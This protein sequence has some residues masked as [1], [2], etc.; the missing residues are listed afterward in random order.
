MLIV[1]CNN[2]NNNN[3]SRGYVIKYGWDH[4]NI[5]SLSNPKMIKDIENSGFDGIMF[6]T[7]GE[8]THDVFS[9]RHVDQSRIDK[10]F[11]ALTPNTFSKPMRNYIMV[12]IDVIE[13]GWKGKGTE[14]MVENMKRFAKAAKESGMEGIAFDNESYR[15]E[16]FTPTNACPDLSE[17]DCKQATIDAGYEMMSAILDVWPNVKFLSFFGIWIKD[18]DAVN[19]I[20]ANS[21]THAFSGK[22]PTLKSDFLI[23]VYAAID[24]R[25]NKATFIDGGEIYGME[26]REE[27]KKMRNYLQ[28]DF[29][30]SSKFFDYKKGKYRQSYI[31]N[32]KISFGIWDFRI[33]T[34]GIDPYKPKRLIEIV[35]NSA[36]ETEYVWLYT[37]K[38]DWWPADGLHDR[39][40]PGVRD[41][42]MGFTSDSLKKGLREALTY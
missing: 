9:S 6:G 27:F 18:K 40:K 1:S 10:A 5:S 3:K 36:K 25:G 31:D 16:P 35:M 11:S 24:E 19:Y 42:A 12:Y 33:P 7:G 39:C 21:P 22:G 26:E 37:E 38:D 2:G 14:V 13:G 8:V 41:G 30:K 17:A 4:P 20:R 28:N 29:P 32:A 23:G 15:E 34:Y